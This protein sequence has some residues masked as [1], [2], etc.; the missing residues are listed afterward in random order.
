L[1]R[2]GYSVGRGVGRWRRTVYSSEGGSFVLLS[3]KT[4]RHTLFY[5]VKTKPLK[6]NKTK[7]NRILVFYSH[8]SSFVTKPSPYLLYYTHFFVF[9][10]IKLELETV[11]GDLK[12]KQSTHTKERPE[13]DSESAAR[14]GRDRDLKKFT[15]RHR[16]CTVKHST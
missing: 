2:G 13:S 1:K 9:L 4:K 3:N 5:A 10:E 16:D 7:Q 12:N 15:V 11:T 14:I 8:C 6:Q